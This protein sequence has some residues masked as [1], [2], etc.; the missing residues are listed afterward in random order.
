MQL[1]VF[2]W[3]RVQT[4]SSDVLSETSAAQSNTF[5]DV[6]RA[7]NLRGREGIVTTG[8]GGMMGFSQREAT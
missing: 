6:M 1:A 2:S 8:Q 4:R 3:G 5:D 7:I